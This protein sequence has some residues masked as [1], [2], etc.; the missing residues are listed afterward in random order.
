MYTDM[1]LNHYWRLTQEA[2]VIVH[3]GVIAAQTGGDTMLGTRL[4]PRFVFGF[5][6]AL[7]ITQVFGLPMWR[8]LPTWS[9]F[10]PLLLYSAV[11]LWAYSWIPDEDGNTWVRL[12]EIFTIPSTFYIFFVYGWF[13]LFLFLKVEKKV[14]GHVIGVAPEPLGA[15][16]QTLY[17]GAAV[18]IYGVH[19]ALAIACQ[20]MDWIAG[21]VVLMMSFTA[22]FMTGTLI[23]YMFLRRAIPLRIVQHEQ[24]SQSESLK[25]TPPLNDSDVSNN[26][27]RK[28][29]GESTRDLQ[30]SQE[31]GHAYKNNGFVHSDFDGTKF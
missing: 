30:Q 19:T 29:S 17:L 3:S 18:F 31:S 25:Q 27:D 14:Y 9:R 12:P 5:S 7:V 28:V 20:Y 1:H 24:S 15:C 16:K 22:I 13:L 6:L 23:A 10:V 4:W 2:W 26:D 21:L 8:R 11:T